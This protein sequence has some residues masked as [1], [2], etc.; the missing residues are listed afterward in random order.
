MEFKAFNLTVQGASHIKKN[1]E[2]QD[3]SK[4]FF[5]ADY[6][7]AVVCDGHGGED[8]IRSAIGSEMASQIALDNIKE[9]ILQVDKDY[10]RRHFDELLYS[11]EGSII[12]MWR[13]KIRNHWECNPITEEE[14]SRLSDKA[15]KRYL[16]NGSI[17]SAYGTTLIAV[18]VTKNY[19][20][21]FQVG[22]GRCVW[23]DKNSYF[24][25]LKLDDKCF[26]NATT[27]L[28]DSNALEHFHDYYSE[29]IP[30]AVFVGS[31]GI[32]D[33]FKNN[34]QLY[35]FYKTICYSFGTTDI[36]QAVAELNDFLPRLSKKGSGDD[37]SIASVLNMDLLPSIDAV[38]RFNRDNERAKKQKSEEEEAKKNAKLI[39]DYQRKSEE[40][41]LRN[42]TLRLRKEVAENTIKMVKVI[43]D[44]DDA[45]VALN[46][47]RSN[48]E[49][50]EEEKNVYLKKITGNDDG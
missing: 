29:E 38:T 18:V 27:S 1:R 13:D 8:Y 31:D 23:I 17:A 5:C 33:C 36:D 47:A 42:N 20:F 9:F 43:Q 24:D 19:W 4:S 6:G 2:C 39:E 34:E 25:Q 30:P 12:S 22:D 35:N 37:V 41:L 32:D 10:L 15:I 40:E 16:I 3:A 50:A 45:M 21:C 46:N 7:I 28:C 14:K 26:L 49:K 11:L 44:L 48:L